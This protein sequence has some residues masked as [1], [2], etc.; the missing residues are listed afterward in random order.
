MYHVINF[1]LNFKVHQNQ[2]MY[3]IF[4]IKL[5]ISNNDDALD[6][7]KIHK[8]NTNFMVH[9]IFL[10]GSVGVG[11]STI[12]KELV[13]LLRNDFRIYQMKEYIDIDTNGISRLKEFQDGKLSKYSFHKYI[14]SWYKQQ[15][16]NSEFT[17][18]EIVLWERH[19][20]EALEIF[21]SGTEGITEI[22]KEDLNT[23]IV[24]FCKEYAI[25][26]AHKGCCKVKMLDTANES[27]NILV[28]TIYANSIAQIRVGEYLFSCT[29]FLYCS[30]IELQYKRIIGRGRD[31][32]ISF[33][34]NRK[35]LSWINRK[36]FDYFAEIVNQVN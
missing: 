14:I 8:K 20:I 32:E 12:L 1:N 15:A 27:V 16:K 2:K 30:D 21:C 25:P 19:P 24:E 3:N 9:H 11:K 4:L 10:S 36:Y 13:S 33:Y 29:F 34:M 5:T 28:E 23:E 18:A 31:S 6:K 26:I 17:S 7:L 22:E 35:N